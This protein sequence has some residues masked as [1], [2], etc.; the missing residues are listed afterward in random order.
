VDP[1][2]GVIADNFAV[3]W[4]DALPGGPCARVFKAAELV[5]VRDAL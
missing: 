5:A 2:R 1:P 4:I 3:P